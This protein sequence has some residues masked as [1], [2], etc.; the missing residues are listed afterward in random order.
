MSANL[1]LIL[2]LAA[3]GAGGLTIWKL[4]DLLASQR[5]GKA[6]DISN[7]DNRD[8]ADAAS[9]ARARVR[10]CRDGGGV[11]DRAAGECRRDVPQ[12]R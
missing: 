10:A 4:A 11:W 8:V 3:L 6:L 12:P 1:R 2:L 9:E 5:V 7:Q